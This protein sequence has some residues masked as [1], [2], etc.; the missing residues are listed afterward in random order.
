[1]PPENS[2]PLTLDEHRELGS[3]MKA[4]TNRLRN[5]C[6]LIVHVYGPNNRAAF[7]FLKALE[8]MD[9]LKQ[10]LQTQATHDMPGHPSNDIYL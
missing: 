10:D 6:D 7:S 8:A 4:A 1:M 2:I 3:E 9:R 5:L